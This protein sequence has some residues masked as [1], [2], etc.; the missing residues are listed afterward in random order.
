MF[1]FKYDFKVCAFFR[2]GVDDVSIEYSNERV[3]ILF[4]WIS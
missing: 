1:A 2:N 3:V 4:F